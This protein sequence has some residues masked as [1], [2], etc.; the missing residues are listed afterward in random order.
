M[1]FEGFVV[2]AVCVVELFL[3]NHCGAIALCSFLEGHD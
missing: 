1:V 3:G 2:A